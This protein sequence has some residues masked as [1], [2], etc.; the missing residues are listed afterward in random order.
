MPGIIIGNARRIRRLIAAA[1]ALLTILNVQMASSQTLASQG[2]TALQV[3]V[4]AGLDANSATATGDRSA[5]INAIKALPDAASRANALGQ[6][7]QQSYTL[8]PQLAIQ[9]MD[10]NE[11]M[12]HN[13][14]VERR[15]IAADAGDSVPAVG[16][17]TI[18][19]ML[20]GDVRQAKYKAGRDRPK[21]DSDSRSI[22]FS[23]DVTPKKGLLIGVNLGIDGIDARL[24]QNRPRITDFNSHI[25]P[26]ISYSNGIFYVDTSASYNLSDFK[27]RRE[28]RFT[29]FIGR[30]T[31][32]QLGDNWAASGETGLMLKV[33]KT[34]IQPFVGVH[35]RYAD[36]SGFTEQGGTAA[37]QVA[38]YRTQLVQSSAGIRAS[39]TIEAGAWALRP[40]VSGEWRHELA[41]QP[42]SRIEARLASADVGIWTL[43][44]AGLK[45]DTANVSAG[46]TATY[47]NR[48]S[49]RLAYVG[50]WGSDRHVNGATATISR[51]F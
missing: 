46:I 40:T 6:I 13:Y 38:K 4:G 35:Y 43:Q 5:M 8:L 30:L 44:P 24:D 15:N 22:A 1:L 12:L 49:F 34:R 42:D 17:G 21:A 29:G 28:V 36:V 27:L 41:K 39:T 32:T 23:I 37:L 25:G 3:A 9:S 26:Y 11:T 33:R 7:S 2:Q 31:A 14:I 47:K 10:A 19:M 45:R 16:D 18:H 48:T 50:E 51:R 20:T